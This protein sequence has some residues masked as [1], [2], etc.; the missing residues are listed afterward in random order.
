M[1]KSCYLLQINQDIFSYFNQIYFYVANSG[2]LTR[3][4]KSTEENMDGFVQDCG[5][6]IANTMEIPLSIT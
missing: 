2:Q 6:S 1:L 3:Q 5:N 4:F